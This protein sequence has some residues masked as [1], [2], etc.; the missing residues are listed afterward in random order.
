MYT[1]TW[2]FETAGRRFKVEARF[3]AADIRLRLRE[4]DN[5]LAEHL[6]AAGEPEA[7]D[8]QTVAADLPEGRLEAT[9]GYIG[10]WTVAC[11]ARLNGELVFR[12]KNED[13]RPPERLRKIMAANA[14]GS[15]EEKAARMARAN[16]RMPSI[17][18][19]I[20]LGILF[21]VVARQTPDWQFMGVTLTGLQTAALLGAAVTSVLFFV[22]KF[23]KVDLL[24]GLAVFGVVMALISAGLAIA[25]QDDLFV[26]L[27][28]TFVGLIAASLFLIDGLAGGRYLGKRIAGYL[29]TLM[30]LNP[31]R[32]SFALAFSGGLVAGVD[33]IAAF[34]LQGDAWLVYNSFLDGFVA[35]PIVLAAFW[36]ARER[37]SAP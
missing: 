12:S 8:P 34:A 30:R 17:Y 4:G 24:G 37:R 1:S 31:R 3:G 10:W 14:S 29:E 20:A 35:I 5:V 32:A 7:L 13:F 15:P 26:K 9:I 2:R 11:Q 21:F 33:L 6:Y 25:F 18:V 36:L 16:A 22:Q 27:R 23:V 28:G 19:D